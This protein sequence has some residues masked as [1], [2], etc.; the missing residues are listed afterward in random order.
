MCSSGGRAVR[1]GVRVHRSV[2]LVSGDVTIHRGVPVTRPAR[3]IADLRLAL[4]SRRP[5]ALSAWELRRAVRQANVL[6]LSVDEETRAERNRSDLEDDFLAICERHRL[7]EPQVNVYVGPHLVDFL[8]PKHRVVVETDGYLYHR[9]KVAF[10]DDRGRD[11]D[12]RRRGYTV[13]RLSEKQVN[14]Q[15]GLVAEV[16][17]ASLRGG[18]DEKAV[19]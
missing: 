14:E 7:P 16:L 18:V 4:G 15:P 13:L 17:A 19:G 5:G 2:S 1:V 6:G 9:G 10:Q 8:W 11:L 12:L 3:T